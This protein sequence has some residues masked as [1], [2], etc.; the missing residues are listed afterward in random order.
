VVEPACGSANDY[1]FL[2]RFG[3]ARYL[4]Y[5]GFDLCQKNVQNAR[6]M[7][8][9]VRFEVGNILEIDAPDGAF[10]YAFVHDLFEHLSVAAME[11]AIA[12]LCR[13]TRRAACVGFF[14]V[15]AGD[16]HVVKA[17][18]EYHWNRLSLPATEAVFRRHASAVEVIHIDAFLRRRFGCGDTHNKGA[19]TFIVTM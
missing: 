19:Y 15:H 9:D 2:E 7:L 14:H 18:G 10:E 16:R 6:R 12:E 8:P 4:D 1:R 13:V 3:I 11:R 17:V 5:T